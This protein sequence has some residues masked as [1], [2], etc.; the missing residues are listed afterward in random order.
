ME[1]PII[2][3][4]LGLLTVMDVL[5]LAI[6]IFSKFMVPPMVTWRLEL[7]MV[8]DSLGMLMVM[9]V[10]GLAICILSKF[11]VPPMVM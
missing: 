5:G 10:L 7:P 1:L 11:M 9:D 6:C 8:M 2:M 3:D 4:F